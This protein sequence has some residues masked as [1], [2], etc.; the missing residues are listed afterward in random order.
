M[1]KSA[2][3]REAV[4]VMRLLPLLSLLLL[5]QASLAQQSGTAA[6]IQC[7]SG[8]EGDSVVSTIALENASGLTSN[9]QAYIRGALVGRCFE[10]A[11]PDVLGKIV[12]D[13]LQ[14][15][16]YLQAF[17]LDPTVRVLNETLPPH[18]A[19]VV[20]D[21]QTGP[22]YRIS[23]IVITG[24]RWID[25]DELRGFIPISPGDVLDASRVQDA[26]DAIRSLYVVHGYPQAQVA[27]QRQA[28][29]SDHTA[30]LYLHIHD[31]GS[32]RP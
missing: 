9:E 12:F 27:S 28:N 24:N 17:V 32:V 2:R 25:A 16:G 29:K 13:Y 6:P 22:P 19:V 23:S 8:T 26:V 14:N 10:Q 4:M 18:P 7:R 30:T 1:V 31:E 21:I 5:S 11:S 20:L 3:Q 15:I